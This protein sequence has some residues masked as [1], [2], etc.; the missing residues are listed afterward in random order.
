VNEKRQGFRR[1]NKRIEQA[2]QKSK[3]QDKNGQ[4]RTKI[5]KEKER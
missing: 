1:K 2:M 3:Q 5:D 4:E